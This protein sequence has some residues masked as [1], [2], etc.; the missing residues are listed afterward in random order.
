MTPSP[1]HVHLSGDLTHREGKGRTSSDAV[2]GVFP[3]CPHHGAGRGQCSY[4]PGQVRETGENKQ[5]GL[6]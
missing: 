6:A 1:S 2:P 4:A 5:L 3:V